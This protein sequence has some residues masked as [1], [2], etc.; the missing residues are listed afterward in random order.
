MGKQMKVVSVALAK[1]LLTVFVKKSKVVLRMLAW[2]SLK[3]VS[4]T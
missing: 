2:K 3:H 4:L 1:L